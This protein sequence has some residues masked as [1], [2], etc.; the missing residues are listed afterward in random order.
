LSR[1]ENRKT[2]EAS[3]S[4]TIDM[5]NISFE[6]LAWEHVDF[7]WGYSHLC[8]MYIKVATPLQVCF[9]GTDSGNKD[10]IKVI[11]EDEFIDASTNDRQDQSALV[12]NCKC[13]STLHIM[14]D[15]IDKV[16]HLNVGFS[17]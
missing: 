3:E 4:T 12:I 9:L 14:R 7:R 1:P 10:N 16:Y 13:I 2:G 11:T 6:M 5:P 17:T 8:E 15:N